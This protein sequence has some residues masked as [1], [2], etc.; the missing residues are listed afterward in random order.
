M[1]SLCNG[2][3]VVPQF[4]ESKTQAAAEMVGGLF[5]YCFDKVGSCL[6]AM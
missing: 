3:Q 6:A 2:G 5:E 4:G 1:I